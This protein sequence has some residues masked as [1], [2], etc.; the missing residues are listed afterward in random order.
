MV[1]KAKAK[2]LPTKKKAAYFYAKLYPISR[3]DKKKKKK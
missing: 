1:K 2:K 3:Y